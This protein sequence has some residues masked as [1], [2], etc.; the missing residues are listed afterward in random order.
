MENVIYRNGNSVY[1]KYKYSI[2]RHITATVKYQKYL[3]Y[4]VVYY[5]A[6]QSKLAPTSKKHS[7]VYN[8]LTI[9]IRKGGN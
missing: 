5:T 4:L 8:I 1:R 6:Y 2:Y 3:E 7:K 9:Q